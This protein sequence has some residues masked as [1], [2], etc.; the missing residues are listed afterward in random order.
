MTF[1]S[2]H[3]KMTQDQSVSMRSEP[4]HDHTSHKQGS[5]RVDNSLKEVS[6]HPTASTPLQYK[7]CV[8]IMSS[9][10][11]T[12]TVYIL[13]VFQNKKVTNR[14]WLPYCKS[15]QDKTTKP[16]CGEHGR[17]NRLIWDGLP[18]VYKASNNQTHSDCA[19]ITLH[20]SKT[21]CH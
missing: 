12:L 8:G 17:I 16:S 9:F 4:T 21:M 3:P 1:S 10:M 19:D 2:T 14:S 18:I 7:L 13:Q 5:F 20:N 11:C 15:T 6:Y